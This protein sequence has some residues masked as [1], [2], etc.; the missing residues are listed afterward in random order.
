MASFM[1]S[2]FGLASTA[3]AAVVATGAASA[4]AA[5][6]YTYDFN[7]KGTL[8]ATQADFDANFATPAHDPAINLTGG[9]SGT[10]AIGRSTGGSAYN[11]YRTP[12]G[13]FTTAGQS[14][15]A[16]YFFFGSANILA[17]ANDFLG[18]TT[19]TAN[20]NATSTSN[21]NPTAGVKVALLNN[22]LVNSAY[23]NTSNRIVSRNLGGTEVVTTDA[24]TFVLPVDNAGAGR[25][26]F[27]Q[28]LTLTY[29][30]GN[31]FTIAT[32]LFESA[33]NGTVGTLLDTYQTTRTGLTSLVGQDLYAGFQ[34]F[35]AGGSSV[36]GELGD[37][38]EVSLIPEPA[39]LA[40]LALGGLCCL[41]RRSAK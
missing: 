6:L 33:S 1:F 19:N 26:W 12:I 36:R 14:T 4:N 21:T 39:S 24:D 34:L 2:S 37:N 9:L 30:G 27:Y 35:S 32:S 13:Q 18:F 10:G 8:A 38:F 25:R 11:Y 29:D 16:S 7:T 22:A 23:T 17:G 40:M 15:T 20:G 5:T 28:T 41:P 31:N 3:L